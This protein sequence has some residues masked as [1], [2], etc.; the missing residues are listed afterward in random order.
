MQRLG[1][2]ALSLTSFQKELW[3]AHETLPETHPGICCG[4]KFVLTG[5]PD[6]E[7]MAA[8]LAAILK[9]FPLLTATLQQEVTAMPVL[10]IGTHLQPDFRVVDLRDKES[11]EQ[12]AKQWL[13]DFREEP[14]EP[15][16]G[17]LCRFALLQLRDDC[18]WFVN[19]FFH[20]VGDGVFG[21]CQF[22]L[23]AEIYECLRTGQPSQLG[24]PRLWDEDVA[25]DR[26]YLASRK[27]QKDLDFW[28]EYLKALPDRRIFT[29]RPGRPDCI[30]TINRFEHD[31]SPAKSE[32]L[33]ALAAA[34]GAGIS[35]VFIA[36]H[37]VV[38][39]RLYDC[40]TL[41]V[42]I[43]LRFGE[44]RDHRNIQGHRVNVAPLIVHLTA[45]STFASTLGD[46]LQK[47]RTLMRRA[48]TPFQRGLRDSG[49]HS[50]LSHIWDTNVNFI[51]MLPDGRMGEVSVLSVVPLTSKY[52][53]VLLGIYVLEG[54]P[55]NGF[56][57]SIDYSGNHFT[58]ADVENYIQRIVQLLDEVCIAPH[59]R[60]EHGDSLLA[61]ERVALTSWQKGEPRS[62]RQGTIPE[63]FSQA[64]AL[65]PGRL[66]VAGEMN[67]TYLEVQN[68][69]DGIALWLAEKGV[70]PGQVVGVLA[71]RHPALPEAILGI[72]K[73]GAVYLPLDPDYPAE[74]LRHMLSDS[75]AELVLA[76]DGESLNSHDSSIVS[77]L[78]PNCLPE[79]TPE[80]FSDHEAPAY[81]IY[82]SGSTGLAKGVLIPH[83]GFVNM[84]QGQIAAFGISCEDRVLQFASPSF[85]ASLSEIFMA[86]LAGA[87]LYPVSRSLIEEPWELKSY[88][89][90]HQVTV[91]T[92]PP[93]YLRL[94]NRESLQGLR[95][96]ITAGEAPVVEDARY[97]AAQLNYF[98]AYGPTEASV[99]ATI[100]IVSPNFQE[101]P[102]RIGRP[103][104]NTSVWIL[105][106]RGRQVAPGIPGEL[107]LGGVGLALGYLNRP[108][109]NQQRFITLPL[110]QEQ[111]L[112][113]SGD[114]AAWT[115]DGEIVLL[116]RIDDQVKIRGH[117]VELGEIN[118]VLEQHSGVSQA[119]TLALPRSAARTEL[120]SFLVAAPGADLQ[121]GPL[122]DWL[123]KRLPDYMLPARFQVLD[124][125][126]IA[127]T[128]KIDK[129]AL[130]QTLPDVVSKESTISQERG[131]TPDLTSRIRAIF[132]AVLNQRA[133]EPA[134]DFFALG[135][136]SLKVI[137]VVR[138]LTKELGVK[139]TVRQFIAEATIEAVAKR[140][141]EPGSIQTADAPLLT[142]LPLNQGQLQLWIQDCLTGPTPRYNMPL[143]ME[144]IAE[145]PHLER[146]AKA[147]SQAI[148]NQPSCHC[149]V[150]GE[151][152][153]PFLKI[154]EPSGFKL[155]R[156][157]FSREPDPELLTLNLFDKRIHLPFDLTCAPLVRADLVRLAPT[158]WQ[159]LLV[160]HHLISDAQSLNILLHDCFRIAQGEACP[161]VSP[162]LLKQFADAEKGYLGSSE[163]HAD[164]AFWKNRLTPCPPRLDLLNVQRPQVKKGVGRLVQKPLSPAVIQSLKRLAD[165]AGTSV[166]GG[167]LGLVVD[168]LR[169]QCVC[170]DIAVAVPVGLRD[171]PQQFTV[172]GYFVNTV[173]VRSQGPGQPDLL[174]SVRETA[175]AFRAA[176]AHSRYPFGLLSAALKEQRDPSRGPLVDLMVTQIDSSALL[177]DGGASAD[178]QLHPMDIDLRVAKLDYTFILHTNS[179][180]R[181]N[182]V[183][184]YDCGITSATEADQLLE[185]LLDFIVRALA[186]QEELPDGTIAMSQQE[187]L[188]R[189]WRELLGGGAPSPE[190]N[191]F[192]SGGDSIKAIQLVGELRR[193]GIVNLSPGQVFQFPTFAKLGAL[194][195][196]D[197]GSVLAADLQVPQ[198]GDV[199]PLLPIQ[200]WLFQKHFEHWRTFH[201]VLPLRLAPDIDIKRLKQALRTLPMRHQ[202]LRM[203]FPGPVQAT[204]LDPPSEPYW[205]SITFP[206]SA[207]DSTLVEGCS[208]KL[209]ANLDPANG[210][211]FGAVLAERDQDRVLLI[212]GHHLILDAISLDLL[213]RELA[214]YCQH[215]DWPVRQGEL[216][217]ATWAANLAAMG[218]Q[219]PGTE[220]RQVWEG[221]CAAPHAKLSALRPDGVDRAGD[222][223]TLSRSL[224]NTLLSAKPR[225]DLLA[226]LASA[227]HEQGQ[228]EP[229]FLT[230]E[231]HGREEVLPGC[232]LSQTVGWFTTAF[233][234]LLTPAKDPNKAISLLSKWFDW[235]PHGGLGYGLAV[236][237]EPQR[238]EYSSQ[239]SLN[240]LGRMFSGENPDG[241]DVITALI[242]PDAIDGMLHEEFQ[243]D[244]PLDLIV[245]ST[246]QD[247]VVLSAYYSP[248]CLDDEW[249]ES[250]LSSW[251]AVLQKM[252]LANQSQS[253][254]QRQE[255]A[256][257]CH[258]LPDE[259][260]SVDTPTPS[261]QG[262]LFQYL[263]DAG[264]TLT[265]T[266]QINFR[267]EGAIEGSLL[268]R[269]WE[270]L[271]ARHASL[272]SLFPVFAEG[273]FCRVTLSA[274]RST[275]EHIDLSSLPA[276]LQQRELEW[277]LQEKRQFAFD[278]ATGPLLH[279]Q[280]FRLSQNDYSMSWTFHHV[281]MDGWCV[282]ILLRELFSSYAEL[283]RGGRPQ[284]RPVPPLEDYQ[285]W[286]LGCDE[287]AARDFWATLLANFSCRTPLSNNSVQG[288]ERAVAQQTKEMR[289]DEAA[290][291]ALNAAA[292]RLSTTLAHLLQALW[293]I[294]LSH[295]NE[296]CRDTVFGL[297]CSG[298]PSEVKQI[299]DM[300][301]LFIQTLP[302]RL[303][304]KPN[305]PF[306]DL[307]SR[308]KA[309]AIER[310]AHEFLHLAEI[311]RTA[312]GNGPLF[313]HILVFENYPLDGILQE[314]APRIKSVTGFEQHPYPFGLSVIPGE[315]LG[316]RFSYSPGCFSEEDLAG[317]QENWLTLLAV[318]REGTDC[319]CAE[320][321]QVLR[322]GV[323]AKGPETLCV[324]ASD[325]AM[326]KKF[327]QTERTYPRN[328]SVCTHFQKVAHDYPRQ[329][330]LIGTDGEGW[331][332]EHL[333]R[334][335][336][337][338]GA[339]L[340]E[341][342][343]GEPIAFALPRGPAAVA[344][345]LGILKAGGCYLPIDDKNPP[346]RVSKMLQVAGC[347]RVLL[348]RKH[349]CNFG[350]QDLEV[351]FY[352]DLLLSE[353]SNRP[354]APASGEQPAYVMFTSGSSGEPKGVVVPH[355]AILRLV[356]NSDF[357][358]IAL[359]ERL[360]QAGPLGFDASTLE[361]WGALLNGATVCF[362]SDDTLLSPGGL[363]KI[364]ATQ[365]ITQMWL[366]ASL[367]NLFAD[368][369][370]SVFA[371]LRRLLTGGEILS[372][373]HIKK[374]LAACPELAIF[375]G[376]GPTENT[377]FTTVHRITTADLQNGSIPIGKPIA[378]SRVHILNDQ[379]T[380]AKVGEW[381]EI[382]AAG[383]G[384]AIG[385]I[386]R[387]DLTAEVFVELPAPVSE[388]VYRTGDIGRWRQD[389]R[390]E[391]LGRR[392]SQVK[393]RGYRIELSEIENA[394]SRLD[395]V[396]QAAVVTVGEGESRSLV[397]YV[398][399]AKGG[400]ADLRAR[401]EQALPGYM[402]PER[403]EALEALPI[404]K[405]GKL[406]RAALEQRACNVVLPDEGA[407]NESVGDLQKRITDIF[408]DVLGVA[409]TD[410]GADFFR[411]GGQSLKA[412]RLLSRLNHQL[413]AGLSLRDVMTHTTVAA[414]ARKLGTEVGKPMATGPAITGIGNQEDYPLSSG[415]ERLWF[416]QQLHPASTVYNVPFAVRLN[417]EIVADT[418]QQALLLLEIRHDALRLR[419]PQSMGPVALRQRL[420]E[421]G[422]LRLEVR[423]FSA[424]ADPAKAVEQALEEELLRPF[425]FGHD[426]R[427]LRAIMFR[428]GVKSSVLL[429]NFHHTICDGWSSEILLKDFQQAYRR[430][431]QRDSSS[432]QPLPLRYVDYATWQREFLSG[433]QGD[434][435]RQRWLERMS[436]LP[437][438]LN[439]PLDRPR[440]PV[441]SFRGNVH[442][443]SLSAD[444]FAGLNE[445]ARRAGSSLFPVLAAL[446]KTFLYRHTGQEDLVVGVPVAGRQHQELEGLVGFFVNTVPL[447]QR[448]V[449][450]A[451]FDMLVQSLKL[452]FE[453]AL[454]D[455][456]YPLEALVENLKLPREASRNPL[457]DVLVAL[458]EQD[459]GRTDRE[460]G[461]SMVPYPLPHRHSKLD[462]SFYFRPA[463][464]GLSV[465]IEYNSDLFDPSTVARMAA[466]LETLTISALQAPH[467]PLKTLDSMP[468]AEKRKILE[469]FNDT[470]VSWALDC[471]IDDLFSRQVAVNPNAVALRA[472]DGVNLDFAEF[473]RRVALLADQLREQGVAQGTYVG[474]CYDRGIDLLTGIFAVL[475]VGGVYV[476]FA[477]E[478]PSARIA[479]MARDLPGCVFLAQ[480]EYAQ[481]F[482]SQGLPLLS[483]TAGSEHGAEAT[484]PTA[485]AYVIFTSGSTGQPK[486]VE[487]EHRS[488]VNR[489]WW[490][491]SQFPI[492]ENDVILQKTP[493]S[494]DVSVWEL[495]WWSWTGA[496]LAQLAPGQEK[497]PAA[498]VEAVASHG[499]TVIHF[500]PSMLRVFLDYL[501]RNEEAVSQVRSLRYLFASGEALTPDL[502]SRC[503]RLLHLA[504]GTELHN[505]YGPTEATVDVTWH[506]C[507]PLAEG[508][509][510]PIGRPVS[511]TSIYILDKSRQ[512]T[513]IGVSGEIFIGGDQVA[514]GYVNRPEL[515]AERFLQDPFFV[516][517]RMYRT[518][519]LGRWLPAGVIEYLGRND[520]QV[521]IRGF[522]I[523]LGEVE[524]VLEQIDEISQA[525]TR[526]VDKDG[527]SYLEAFLVPR[528]KGRL[529]V[530][531]IRGQVAKSLPD[532]MIPAI[533]YRLEKLPLNSSGKVDRKALSGQQL[534]KEI[535][536][537]SASDSPSVTEEKLIR[538]WQQVLPGNQEIGQQQNFF[539]LGGNSLL[540]IRLH[541]HLGAAWPGY[542]SLAQLFVTVT[543]RQQAD[544]ILKEDSQPVIPTSMPASKVEESQA[545]AV[546]GMAL[547]LADYEEP[548]ALWSDLLAGCDRTG[549]LSAKRRQEMT[550]MLAAIGV[551][552]H[553]SQIRNAAF[554]DDISSF[555][556]KRFG[557]A[558][559]DVRLLDPEQRLFLE[560]GYRALEDAGYGGKALE[561][562]TVG[563]FAGS[564][565]SATFKEAVSRSFPESIEQG[566]ILNV[567][568]NMATRLGYLMNWSGPASL[569][570]TACSSSLKA[571]RDACQA[572]LR[573]EC[574][575]AVAGGARVVLTPLRSEQAFSIETTT[576]Q[577][578]TFDE[579]A[580]GVGAG[581]GA[582]VLLL[583]PLAKAEADGDAIRAV[584][585]GGAVN[586]D[587]R[588][589]SMAAPNPVAQGNVITAAARDAKI[590]L[591]SLDFFEAHGTGTALGDP[592][593]IDG[594][595]RAFAG[596]RRQLR[597]AAIS[598]VKGNF[599]HLDAAA[600]ALGLAKVILTLEHG[601]VPRQPHF[602]RPNGRIDFA[603]APVFVARENHPLDPDRRPWRAGVSAFGLSGINVHLIAQQ[604]KTRTY[605]EDDGCWHVVPLSASSLEGLTRYSENLMQTV[606]GHPEWPLHAIA[607]T[608]IAGRDHLPC[609]LAVAARSSAELLT[610]LLVWRL[611][612]PAPTPVVASSQQV[613]L[614]GLETE[615]TAR[616]ARETYLKG[617]EPIWS[618]SR[619]TYR[620]HLP[621]APM[622]RVDCWPRFVP[623]VASRLSGFL[624][625]AVNSP[626]GR[627]HSVPVAAE[628]FWPISEH[629]LAGRPT[630]V[631]LGNVA[632]MAETMEAIESPL[633][634]CIENLNWLRPL[635]LDSVEADSVLLKLSAQDSAWRAELTGCLS[636]GH[637]VTFA[638][639]RLCHRELSPGRIDLEQLRS[640][641]VRVVGKKAVEESLVRVSARWDCRKRVWR[642]ADGMATLA[643]LRLSEEFHADFRQTP[644]H[645]AMLD[646]AASLAL[647]RPNLVPVSCGEIRLHKPLP[648]QLFAHVVKHLAAEGDGRGM[649]CADCQLL[650]SHG[651][652]LVELL[653]LVFVP[654]QQPL[655][656]LHRL[657]WASVQSSYNAEHLRAT[658]SRLLLLGS[659]GAIE[660]LN[661][662]LG[663]LGHDCLLRTMPTDDTGGAT[664]AAEIL[665]CEI[666]HIFHLLPD[667]GFSVWN[668]AAQ[669]QALIR[670]GLRRPLQ[671]LVAGEGAVGD[672]PEGG[673]V[674]A[675]ALP[676]AALA[677]GLIL[678][679]GHEEPLLNAVYAEFS[680]GITARSV[681]SELAA[682]GDSEH[683]A[684]IIAR[685]G[686]RY[687]RKLSAPLSTGEVTKLRAEGTCVV[688][689]GGLGAMAL[690][691]AT[692]AFATPGQAIALL[693]RGKF[694]DEAEWAQL[695]SHEDPVLALRGARLKQLLDCGARV[696]L[697]SCDVSS[698][699]QL[700]RTLARVRTELG[701]IGGIIHTAGVAGD[702]FLINKKAKV[703]SAVLAPKV[704]A[705]RHLHD[706]TRDDSLQFFVLASSRTALT[707]AAGQTD[708]AAANAHLDAFAHWRKR[709]GLPALSINWNTWEE[710]GMAAR[711]GAVE[712]QAPNL[713]PEQA[714]VLFLQALASGETQ[715]V[716][717]MP[718][719]S[720]AMHKGTPEGAE[721]NTRPLE[722]GLP[723][724]QQIMQIVARGLGY[725]TPLS[726]TDDFYA[727]GGDSITGMQIVNRINRELDRTVSLADLFSHSRLEH[728]IAVVLADRKIST[729][730]EPRALIV[731]E[732]DSYPV[733]L[734]QLA[735]LH[736][737][738][739]ATPHTGYNLP[740]FLRMSGEIDAKK[741]ES[742]LQALIARH[743]ILRTRFVGLDQALPR[744]ELLPVQSFRLAIKEID[745]LDQATVQSL[746]QPFRL[747]ESPLFRA[748][749]LHCKGAGDVLFFD[750]HH[751]VADAR[752]I[753]ILLGDLLALYHERS[754]APLALQQ[755]EAAWQQHHGKSPGE[756]E[757][758][759]YWMG[760][761]RGDLPL[762][763]LPADH[764][765]P[766]RHT[767]RGGMA[768]FCIPE[769]WIPAIRGLARDY[770]TTTYALMLTLWHLLLSRYAET[771]EL[772]IAVATEGRDREELQAIAGMFVSL[773]PLRLELTQSESFANLLQRNHLRHTEALRHRGYSL[774]RL[775][776][777]LRPPV[778]P[779]RTPLAEVTFS[780]M[781]FASANEAG[782]E[783]FE[784]LKV[785]NPSCKADLAIFASDADGRLSFALEYYADLFEKPRIDLLGRH[786]L[787]LLRQLLDRGAGLPLSDYA[788]LDDIETTRLADFQRGAPLSP[789]D[790]DLIS[791][792]HARAGENGAGLAWTGQTSSLSWERLVVLSERVAKHLV[793]R[794]VAGGGG[795][796]LQV[797]N[798]N[799]LPALML[800][801]LKAGAFCVMGEVKGTERYVSAIIGDRKPFGE[802]HNYQIFDRAQLLEEEPVAGGEPL[803]GRAPATRA[804]FFPETVGPQSELSQQDLLCL[805]GQ[806]KASCLM[807]GD[808]VQITAEVTTNAGIVQMWVALLCGSRVL[809]PR[810]FS[811]LPRTEAV[812]ALPQDGKQ[813]LMAE[814]EL[815]VL[816][817]AR[818]KLILSSYHKLILYGEEMLHPSEMQRWFAGSAA[819]QIFRCV[820]APELNRMM[821]FSS[822]SKADSPYLQAGHPAPGTA[823]KILQSQGGVVP[824]GVW[825]K[826]ILA[827]LLADEDQAWRSTEIVG[828]WR[829]D[830][831]I[832]LRGTLR[833]VSHD[834]VRLRN[835]L[836]G[837]DGVVDAS[838]Q[839]AP[840]GAWQAVLKI[841]P[842]FEPR[843]ARQELR[844]TLP[845]HLAEASLSVCPVIRL[846]VAGG[847]DGVESPD[848]T[849]RGHHAQDQNPVTNLFAGVTLELFRSFFK[850]PAISQDDSFFDLGGHSLL[851]I[852]IINQVTE[853][854][855]RIVT[856]R[857]L[858]D[859][860]TPAELALF[861]EGAPTFKGK[862][863]QAAS[864]VAGGLFPLS[865]AQQRLYVLHHTDGGDAAYNMAFV[866]RFDSPVDSVALQ[867]AMFKLCR[868]H[869]TLRTAFVEEAGQLW[870]VIH[871]DLELP[872]VEQ[873]LNHDRLPEALDICLNDAGLPFRLE[874]APLFRL[875]IC[876]L[877]GGSG[878]LSLVMHHIIGDGWSM[879][880][881]FGELMA[882]YGEELG[883]A[884]SG[885][886]PLE[887]Q[888]K[889]YA[890]WQKDR[891]W[892][893]E[894]DYWKNCLAGAPHHI[895]LPMEDSSLLQ[896]LGAGI[897]KRQIPPQLLERL[898][899]HARN[900]G[901]SLATLMLT[902]F[903]ALLYRLTRQQDMVIGMGVAGRERAELEG[904]IGFFIN[905]LPIRVQIDDDTEINELLDQVHVASLE[906]LERQDYPFDLLVRELKP[907]R[908]S[909]REALINIMFEYQRFSDLQQIN[910]LQGAEL[911]FDC[912]PVD[913][914]DH[915]GP[916]SGRG[917]PAKYD[918]TLFVQ[919]EPA[920]CTL[921]AEFDQR[922]LSMQTIT[923]W[924]EYLELF[925]N[926]V[927][928]TE[929]ERGHENI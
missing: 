704:D 749:L 131:Q 533:F 326:L 86:L 610:E 341:L 453:E 395:E 468:L 584:I 673:S 313:D 514:R 607:A 661:E 493:V 184:E 249:V 606:A 512:P 835:A 873:H 430:I 635:R 613:Q 846:A 703:F 830:G 809:A 499:V 208:R 467:H 862:I 195:A 295:V 644:W 110:A 202:A 390:I 1:K 701:P 739:G 537:G 656:Q 388:R 147:F 781:N 188:A 140:A 448:L 475:R 884:K 922:I 23:M 79:G 538:I 863:P 20:I 182:L 911:P 403:I 488:V 726:G 530:R 282:G 15:L 700:R 608:L 277:R 732:Q 497:D 691:L 290:T 65:A 175:R 568:S 898:R 923:T 329:K 840:P 323:L 822:C 415:Q 854:C 699:D 241:L 221:L 916:G 928:E 815:L 27:A 686:Q 52:D 714:G 622:E 10:V 149:H 528:E 790:R 232:D 212:G 12:L 778:M 46:V 811:G 266:Q 615:A 569:V 256:Q 380:L 847:G 422:S 762:L 51:P 646:V 293:G 929:G 555:D 116:G 459:W 539:D 692:G 546:I 572:L 633:S 379:G 616:S 163:H 433:P 797:E 509:T 756:N 779:D 364:I 848:I 263:L 708:Y 85:D 414:L 836:L 383:D 511:N 570:D 194:L 246:A 634:L 426:Q 472:A 676:D 450:D 595:T 53:P 289:L 720:L 823:I 653:G 70:S 516:G 153:A 281:L 681:L 495:F 67:R 399:M 689:T 791:A 709:Q 649:L 87:R 259:M 179:S 440:P 152:D 274:G 240:Y 722:R 34:H 122:L 123:R 231:G 845:V 494:F 740:Q 816:P 870:Q 160:M 910:R 102:I 852:Q 88:M 872:F 639:A 302:V 598:A 90:K 477:P 108:E 636:S 121:P 143:A 13:A 658:D 894:A 458:E 789:L 543:V 166:F 742:A 233:P 161:A 805:A 170:D 168:Y 621:T 829:K 485:A 270:L 684:V 299:E 411:L 304:W 865:H 768:S 174:E 496:S 906:A 491:Q 428:E 319:S 619:Q 412:M 378:N 408:S 489:I 171:E 130:A 896:A 761:F 294:L 650:D 706:L 55:G 641:M 501:E 98:N 156:Y 927:I 677:L 377:T 763:D 178:L 775:L 490:M 640:S 192:V 190:S 618:A 227:L 504:N 261:Q 316:F 368:E 72:M 4:G 901:V 470:R 481:L 292:S 275:V 57:L 895:A 400:S 502:V 244:S 197:A 176:V 155:K 187:T 771:E 582:V 914:G 764:L 339:G 594:L 347:R 596:Q 599:G 328:L 876:R 837:L 637:W 142:E 273:D 483:L 838:V 913:P 354:K 480:P 41:S 800:G 320:L 897:C 925:M 226:A 451:G 386:N 579:L 129:Q 162:I 145:P 119:V 63:I 788:I 236:Q 733:S 552:V 807:G 50:N 111:R 112:Y 389:G 64:V 525:V 743:E 312:V 567:P 571:V 36:L 425:T 770:A 769:D 311:Q 33:R 523:E 464:M 265:Y 429:L 665:D 360:L 663:E 710:I 126:P 173:I 437:E 447:R 238:L 719:E 505:L 165:K 527:A 730:A 885:L 317:L 247:E 141:T 581:E 28:Q 201:M 912:T 817:A 423:D 900:K 801:V 759:D 588:S 672:G 91:V 127:P 576:G 662:E 128:G 264:E 461:L 92:F 731:P 877:A 879:Q 565:P 867:G 757:S 741:I 578:R 355:R 310:G 601:T 532:Y 694:P 214:W 7:L 628:S 243:A 346:E 82:T 342:R 228:M 772:V 889:D 223:R 666:T 629:S 682:I 818:A 117:R 66:A 869:E 314:G 151:I 14:F 871:E 529:S 813:V 560:T 257:N 392:D 253:L 222:R 137:E 109:L 418:L 667:A 215:G 784:R 344:S 574:A 902:L 330:A 915:Q 702:G 721:N 349:A 211:M 213:R 387:Q 407:G 207:S 181:M 586:Q 334:I 577:T 626:D 31:L 75:E 103:I 903:A 506:P 353:V 381:G 890:L 315:K 18:S 590:D 478:L 26:E 307:L 659:G 549:P 736:A 886:A 625:A 404:T 729:K 62:F 402:I 715:V 795:V 508:A 268:Q 752:A 44:R 670:L 476:P 551:S 204:L 604:A 362:I 695:V 685:Q 484:A 58:A 356:V 810:A 135:G 531:E 338:I 47:Q 600:G 401:L 61:A 785:S 445:C 183:L 515:T 542:F 427:L 382:C 463:A 11:P 276:I 340:G 239:L 278:L 83:C 455:Q 624:G 828:R 80:Q 60:V 97:Y 17:K 909:N 904:L 351:L 74:R 519:D 820:K 19:R 878:L 716:V 439:L 561:G 436:P 503:N 907:D 252:L 833:Q 8:S 843:Q 918:L 95:V 420:A 361:I 727:L 834:S 124:S 783:G 707:G 454:E 920:G 482:L 679:L 864:L 856:I 851:A 200:D 860:P 905:I 410:A 424:A 327:N 589:A 29:P 853:K 857:N 413:G 712:K 49:Q 248:A 443:F 563:V 767:N 16:G 575:L 366:T 746:V 675:A 580:D 793:A 291:Q 205:E 841:E 363:G 406:D 186:S 711:M 774:N 258:C 794:G 602:D 394:L 56:H 336:A 908:T 441:P 245:Y 824:I 169:Q 38:L 157:D 773:V 874:Q 593:E 138:R 9:H 35:E 42:Q 693:H 199:I 647:D 432:W 782:H 446:V 308:V 287:A 796:V 219:F 220:E 466:R 645:P 280:L 107:C 609:R 553:D 744:M 343:G 547:R 806:F 573:G 177:P 657:E 283:S 296:G 444:C 786:F 93:S 583:K 462:L 217:F 652:V 855:G 655:A 831:S 99:C 735:I 113:R 524:S 753:D 104:A 318:I 792:V 357:W 100:A 660:Q 375:N 115:A 348:S 678:S 668:L 136:D 332:Y 416:L 651:D 271:V 71:R 68:R 926:K 125:L 324:S 556:C 839:E 5:S 89:Q 738:A 587:G 566:Y 345:M 808:Q 22:N 435:L 881:M 517:G 421:P 603:N 776:N 101:G 372:P 456:L 755:K 120:T 373:G 921:R 77:H 891:D 235:L 669:L 888:Y 45:K 821:T 750:I 804:F 255:L 30:E 469:S 812:S 337:A 286:L 638:E 718:E 374:I 180:D 535:A 612:A 526:V 209:F 550:L 431:L 358:E 21:L 632:L 487:V 234:L 2:S 883:Q 216:G 146:F 260:V 850:N 242:A 210:R 69:S 78:L 500:V 510:V 132:E 105:D 760:Q 40:D 81:L 309:Q 251:Q 272:R 59:G 861:L 690:T 554:L 250:L 787:N 557:M 6:P 642:S 751:A 474:I 814:T 471:S 780:Y 627:L 24:S 229:V 745:A 614:A 887:I 827:G 335:S 671:L 230:L 144:I 697:Y 203:V 367:C 558:P 300:V 498:I 84:I 189:A 540:L 369:T 882:L 842:P 37:L 507:S 520:H 385:Y 198:P 167:F 303:S 893:I 592:I 262:M 43:P 148:E 725:E 417:D 73:A 365:R 94:F 611:E 322:Q 620:V 133:T 391:F 849:G 534:L 559:G 370:P 631:G 158:R 393:L 866:F 766:N 164:L 206:V 449:P 917:L 522:R 76:L 139:I 154:V 185:S 643:L 698:H 513:P 434:G 899:R 218:G 819:P 683:R 777:E 844:R 617:A 301:G 297:V 832:E 802:E 419:L 134:L 687:V 591:A 623:Q 562:Q 305:E 765:R 396:H 118:M 880:I 298:R 758:R 654:A 473:D 306:I 384:L 585:M 350:L 723:P 465:D 728:F 279:L 875:R 191:F 737:E 486:G 544:H 705:V 3:V 457:F 398:R 919:D 25:R 605:P 460:A 688:F 405:N 331:S 267:L 54:R 664:L 680:A 674:A 284:L 748:C 442:R 438:A 159:L 376:Y 237:R 150:C 826:L 39:A 48:R 858:Y 892:R 713:P 717:T 734:E 397:A 325:L 521:K 630:L 269:A 359:G 333:D 479:I 536:T 747:T 371:P 597:Q 172:A 32:S 196:E 548:D 193:Q 564:S 859:N 409:V 799:E 321:E 452:T 803:S 754:L 518:G 288:H 696:K 106:S 96:L 541:E 254:D 352:E 724:D 114:L 492:G 648:P 545:V 825:G 798:D 224:A 285:Q 924:L 225:V 868:R